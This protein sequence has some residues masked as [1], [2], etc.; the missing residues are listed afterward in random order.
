MPELNWT[1]EMIQRFWAS[2]PKQ[3]YFSYQVGR[4]IV[5]RFRKYLGGR[6]VDYGAGKGHLIDELL[7]IGQECCAVEFDVAELYAE[8]GH[9]RNF[10]GAASPGSL[11]PWSNLFDSAFLVEVIE[12]LYDSDLNWALTHIHM[13]LKPDG[14][15]IITTPNNE[16]R[17]K[18]M[19]TDTATGLR[20]HKYQHVRSWSEVTL[21]MTLADHHF[22][23]VE[24]GTCD[25]AASIHA[26][27]RTKTFG[28]RLIRT[29]ALKLL[30]RRP[31]L[32]CIAK[33][34][35]DNGNQAHLSLVRGT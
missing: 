25:F 5:N 16:D 21:P 29:A 33:K 10:M 3:D 20:Y 19:L 7:R 14:Y 9:K 34:G 31:H 30:G 8:Y 4:V 17:S 11:Q 23:V 26:H 13:L 32:Y 15:L 24:C 6:T 28:E 12:H 35:S 22:D 2:A 18:N 1:P 27:H